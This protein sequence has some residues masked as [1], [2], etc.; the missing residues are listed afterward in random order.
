MDSIKNYTTSLY[1]GFNDLMEALDYARGCLG[2]NYYINP[3][4]RLNMIGVP[5]YNIKKT[6]IKLYFMIIAL[7]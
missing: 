4:L 3:A 1:K 6:Q 5:Q 7:Q 2:P